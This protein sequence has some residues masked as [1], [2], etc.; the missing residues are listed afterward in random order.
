MK[1]HTSYMRRQCPDCKTVTG[2]NACYC[3]SCGFRFVVK[4]TDPVRAMATR[5]PKSHHGIA[6]A[7]GLAVAVLN[8]VLRR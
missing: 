2:G 5:K 1:T 8:Y 4:E 7:V 6:V 3:G